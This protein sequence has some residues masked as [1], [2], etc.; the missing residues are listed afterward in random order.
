V[1]F[2]RELIKKADKTLPALV[3]KAADVREEQSGVVIDKKGLLGVQIDPLRF[4]TTQKAILLSSLLLKTPDNTLLGMDA[5]VNP[6]GFK[7]KEEIIKLAHQV[8]LSAKLGS[9]KINLEEHNDT[10]GIYG[11]DFAFHVHFEKD[12]L[13]SAEQR[14]DF[15]VIN[16]LH[17]TPYSDTNQCSLVIYAGHD[18]SYFFNNYKLDEK[19]ATPTTIS[20]LHKNYNFLKFDIPEKHLY[21]VEQ[22]II[23]EDI[24]QGMIVHIA[25]IAN[26][27]YLLPP[28]QR[29]VESLSLV[30]KKNL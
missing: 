9:R 28:M 8:F 20:F 30:R 24:A 13:A 19:I 23:S 7:Y 29:M 18:P 12:Y 1:F 17:Y 6:E 14:Y 11:S 2:A 27:D 21:L 22:Q 4:D 3:A 26:H 10:I 15:Q 5:Y 25:M 16:V